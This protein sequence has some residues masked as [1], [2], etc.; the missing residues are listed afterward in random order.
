L[1]ISTIKVHDRV[2]PLVSHPEGNHHRFQRDRYLRKRTPSTPTGRRRY[3]NPSALVVPVSRRHRDH[4]PS[5][6]RFS[7]RRLS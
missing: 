5:R 1:L 6:N 2:R 4:Q 3:K 7:C